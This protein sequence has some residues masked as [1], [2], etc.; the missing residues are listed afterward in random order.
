MGGGSRLRAV[1]GVLAQFVGQTVYAL[2]VAQ[3]RFE[4]AKVVDVLQ[5]LGEWVGHG[6]NSTPLCFF[7]FV[8]PNLPSALT[9][10]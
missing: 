8:C 9:Q 10:K 4:K 7:L 3:L 6:V 1:V 5:F 2:H